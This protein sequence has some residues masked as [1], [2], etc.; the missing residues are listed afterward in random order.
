MSSERGWE[1]VLSWLPWWGGR[2]RGAG[3]SQN[4]CHLPWVTRYLLPMLPLRD[5]GRGPWILLQ[6]VSGPWTSFVAALDKGQCRK[7]VCRRHSIKHFGRNFFMKAVQKRS[8]CSN[9]VFPG[10]GSGLDPDLI[11]S[12]N[13]LLKRKIKI[14]HTS[15]HVRILL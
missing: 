6:V 10:S 12:R 14:L 4:T 5:Q 8:R 1:G 11:G 15:L 2:E 7:A 13:D 9:P 3:V